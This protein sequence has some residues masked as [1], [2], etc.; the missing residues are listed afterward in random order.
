MRHDFD[1]TTHNAGMF[2]RPAVV[3]HY[4]QNETGLCPAETMA[5]LRY[6]DTFLGKRVLDIGV[7]AGRT[8][9]AL[10][11]LASDYLGIDLSLPMLD[12]CRAAH[13][14]VRLAHMDLRE[15][16]RFDAASFDFAMGS[17]AVLDVLPQH[18]RLQALDAIHRLLSPGG[19]FVFSAHNRASR[20][21]GQPPRLM[22]SR[23]PVRLA[24]EMRRFLLA[25]LH[26]TRLKPLERIEPDYALLN[27]MAHSWRGVFYYIGQGAQR[28]Q[29][30]QA[31]FAVLDVVGE[32]GRLV[33]PDDD[34]TQDGSLYYVTRRI[35]D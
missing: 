33:G 31:G 7:G 19:H 8:T 5:F 9:R 20:W 15:L 11:D 24:A 13:P 10:R 1:L 30:Q 17:Y 32:N 16:S 4:V 23:N 26:H 2:S 18:E 14:G 6:R 3:R 12:A 21:A 22:S 27:D 25:R 29:L 35:D 34:T 28:D